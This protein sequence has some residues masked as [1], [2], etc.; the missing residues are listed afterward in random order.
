MTV[1]NFTELLIICN[2]HLQENFDNF[3]KEQISKILTDKGFRNNVLLE[4]PKI[5]VFDNPNYGVKKIHTQKMFR[6]DYSS[7]TT[8]YGT[9]E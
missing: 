2:T 9:L 4:N 1:I 7:V 6:D 3:S 5:T 8:Y